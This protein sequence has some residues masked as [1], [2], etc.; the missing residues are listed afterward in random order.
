MLAGAAK[1]CVL[2][3]IQF[4]FFILFLRG[5][6]LLLFKNHRETSGRCM[7]LTLC[8]HYAWFLDF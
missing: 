1:R 6:V 3:E 8:M 4:C 7:K 2:N 5:R